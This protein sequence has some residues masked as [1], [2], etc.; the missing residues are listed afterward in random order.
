MWT[1]RSLLTTAWRET[2]EVVRAVND[3]V[4][5]NTDRHTHPHRLTISER[6][7]HT[8]THK[9]GGQLLYTGHAATQTEVEECVG[10]GWTTC[11]EAP[12]PPDPGMM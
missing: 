2:P 4:C 7:T 6:H 12:D 9:V 3:S 1:C 11:V 8:H 5:A 10:E